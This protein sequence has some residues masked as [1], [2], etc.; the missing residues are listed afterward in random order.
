MATALYPD[1][2][3][4]PVHFFM[5]HSQTSHRF[6][7]CACACAMQYPTQH[8]CVSDAHAEFSNLFQRETPIYL[9][10]PFVLR[11]SLMSFSDKVNIALD[12]KSGVGTLI[13]RVFYSE[14]KHLTVTSF[15]FVVLSETEI[16]VRALQNPFNG[17]LRSFAEPHQLAE[18]VISQFWLNFNFYF[19]WIKEKTA[20]I[21]CKISFL[22]HKFT[23]RAPNRLD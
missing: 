6:V 12:D 10:N 3:H 7:L 5:A 13:V 20:S 8:I 22:K 19:P 14:I 15:L 17:I 4:I 21:W 16:S 9:L 18:T 23:N 2:L 11:S 1:T